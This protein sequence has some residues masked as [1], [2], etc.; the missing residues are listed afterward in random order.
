R[1][2]P[3]QYVEGVAGKRGMLRSDRYKSILIPTQ[4]GGPMWEVYDL[5]SDPGETT[6]LSGKL[7]QAEE[8]LRR[9]LLDLLAADPG[10]NERDEPP[11]PPELE[12]SLRSLG[13]VGSKKP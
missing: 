2:N 5:E 8:T 13:Y 7:P 3:R 11:L 4:T 1:E 6:N 9:A 12:D 10:R